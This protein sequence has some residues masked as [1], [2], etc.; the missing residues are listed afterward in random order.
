[1]VSKRMPIGVIM[2]LR[3]RKSGKGEYVEYIGAASK[4]KSIEDNE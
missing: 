3:L 4:V 1:M 2:I